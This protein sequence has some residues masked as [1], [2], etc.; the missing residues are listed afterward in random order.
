MNSLFLFASTGV[1]A[2]GGYSA[3]SEVVPVVAPVAQ[4]S[5]DWAGA[6]GGLSVGYAFGGDD[7]VGIHNPDG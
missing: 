1:A 5:F 2:A 6:Y 3:P 7:R 4:P